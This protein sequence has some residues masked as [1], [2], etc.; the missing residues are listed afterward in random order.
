MRA[1]SIIFP[2][3]LVGLLLMA[4]SRA[5]PAQDVF[6]AVNF[7]DSFAA[8]G[9]ANSE[10]GWSF[11]PAVD[12]L[13]T[14]INSSGIQV[15][16]WQGSNSLLATYA[17]NGPTTCHIFGGAPTNFQAIP[18]LYLTANQAYFISSVNPGPTLEF[19]IYSINGIGGITPFTTSPYIT[20][21]GSYYHSTNGQWLPTTTP[22]SENVNYALLGPNFQF[23]VVPAPRVSI[24]LQGSNQVVCSSPTYIGRQ[25]ALE[26]AASLPSTNWTT[27]SSLAGNGTVQKWTNAV[28]DSTKFFRLRIY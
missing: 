25:Y 21:F 6:K 11:V 14:G 9:Y 24:Q 10:I 12:L 22:A 15:S 16:F 20:Q 5:L 26:R 2:S 8:T 1:F 4:F 3:V 17:Y 19:F 13:V 27:V 28:T 23:Q 7:P 18:P